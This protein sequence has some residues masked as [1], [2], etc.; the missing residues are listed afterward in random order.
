MN[1]CVINEQT[2]AKNTSAWCDV[3]SAHTAKLNALGKLAKEKGVSVYTLAA[4]SGLSIPTLQRVLLSE[5]RQAT[6]ATIHLF[7]CALSLW[8]KHRPNEGTTLRA[9]C[10]EQAKLL[11]KLAVRG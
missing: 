6:S 4:I 1:D 9:Q 3:T 5:V 2:P 7:A 11:D 10:V 8:M